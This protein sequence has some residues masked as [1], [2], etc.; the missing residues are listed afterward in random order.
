MVIATDF[1]A[2]LDSRTM[3]KD[4]CSVNNHAAFCVMHSLHDWKDIKHEIIE[5]NGNMLSKK[6]I[7][8]CGRWINFVDTSSRGKKNDHVV[9]DAFLNHIMDCYSDHANANAHYLKYR[10]IHADNCSTQHEC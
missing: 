6:N 5:R 3:E 7:S 10:I 2:T 4:N 8:K 1:G 9:H